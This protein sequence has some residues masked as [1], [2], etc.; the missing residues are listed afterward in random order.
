MAATA[1]PPVTADP[2]AARPPLDAEHPHR[3]TAGDNA[4]MLAVVFGGPVVL[5]A[6]A[7][8]AVGST[9]RSLLSGRRPS[10]PALLGTAAVAAYAGLAVPWMRGWGSSPQEM[11]RA[12]PGDE[13]VARPA[14]QTTREIEIDAPVHEVWPWL[15]QIGQDRGGFY[16]YAWLENLAGC[17]MVNA[18]FEHDEWLHRDV[19]EIVPLHPDH[20]VCVARFEPEHVLVLEGWGA[21]VLEPLGET[22]TLLTIRGRS[23]RGVAALVYVLLVEIPHFV[24]E[25]K[26]LLGIKDRAERAYGA[27][28]A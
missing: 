12:L 14:V 5:D 11:H 2:V 27:R 9:A 15:A 24:M 3:G 16:S 28:G 8:A 4:R 10:A 26:M 20:G 17:E 13:L 7:A 6:L 23:P 19:G 25:R 1:T 21:F 22:R 18:E